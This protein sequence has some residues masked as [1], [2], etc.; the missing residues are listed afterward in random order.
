MMAARERVKQACAVKDA[1][2]QEGDEGLDA[3]LAR[4]YNAEEGVRSNKECSVLEL[5]RAREMEMQVLL[6]TPLV[7]KKGGGGRGEKVKVSE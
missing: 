5:L 7:G 4:K 2:I 6:Q 3:S 1:D